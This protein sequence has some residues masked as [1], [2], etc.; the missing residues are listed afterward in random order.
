M[1]YI[2][3]RHLL[4]PPVEVAFSAVPVGTEGMWKGG[5]IVLHHQFQFLSWKVNV[6]WELGTLI[7]PYTSYFDR[8]SFLIHVNKPCTVI[9]PRLKI[10]KLLFK[11]VE[12]TLVY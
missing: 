9:L 8:A 1:S 2:F 10:V 11:M 4:P 6:D 3:L 7:P 5:K 12:W